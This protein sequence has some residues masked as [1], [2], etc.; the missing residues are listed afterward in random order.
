MH[1]FRTKF[2]QYIIFFIV[3]SNEQLYAQSVSFKKLQDGITLYLKNRENVLT[4]IKKL[5]VI[6]EDIIRVQ[7]IPGNSDVTT[8]SIMIVNGIT[9]LKNWQFI[10]GK[11]T[12]TIATKHLRAIVS[13]SSGKITFTDQNNKILTYERSNSFSPINLENGQSA[14]TIRQDFNSSESEAIYGLGQ[15]QQGVVNYKNKNVLLEQLNTEVSIPFW[16]SSK[17]YGILWDNNSLSEYGD[18]RSYKSLSTLTLY[19]KDGETV[20]LTATYRN[21]IDTSK[22][23]VTKKDTSIHY[24]YLNE[25]DKFPKEFPLQEGMVDWEGYLKA[26]ESGKY[27]FLIKYAGYI[28]IWIA[29]KL[30]FDRWRQAWNPGKEP[31]ELALIRNNKYPIKIQW[32]PDG[33]VSYLDVNFLSPIPNQFKNQYSFISQAGDKIDYYFIHGHTSDEIIRGYR[34]LTGKA[35][36]M[37]KWAMGFWQSRQ[38]YKTQSEIINTVQQFRERNI[39]LDNIVLDWQYWKPD[40][41]GS[42]EFDTS[43]FPEPKR[44]IDSLHNIYH[45]NIMISVWPKFNEG[46]SNYEY[47]NKKGW[48]FTKNIQ[49]RRKD[50]L[51]YIS[52]FYDVFNPDARSAFWQLID[53]S[54]YRKGIDAWW[55][56]ASEPDIHSML[57]IPERQELMMP[58]YYG[59]AIKY[60]NAFSVPNAQAIYEGQRSVDSNKRVFILTRSGF[61]G[62][63][64][65]GAAVWSGDIAARWSDMSNQIAAGIN[66]SYSGNPYWTMDIGGFSVENRYSTNPSFDAA[67]EWKE[68]LTR[69]YQFGAFCPLFRAHGEYPFREIYNIAQPN[70]PAYQSILYYDQLR[71]KLM[72][73]IYSLAGKVYWDDYTIMR[74]LSMDFPS[75]KNVLNIGDQYLFGPSLLI[76]PVT[77]YRTISR[78]V[79][80]PADTG[81][82]NIYNGKYY[83]GGQIITAAAP[84]QRIPVFVRAGSIIPLGCD[85]EYTNQKKADTISLYVY[86]GKDGSFNLYED[87]GINYNYEKGKYTIIP[88][89]Y[90]NSKRT[91]TIDNIIS[92]YEGML[93]ERIFKIVL[94]DKKNEVGIDNIQEEH[95]RYVAYKNKKVE[96]KINN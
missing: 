77:N 93:S 92:S 9:T 73:Y 64:R 42:Q 13:L 14:Y 76:N 21:K 94:I 8:A 70:E 75:D 65:Y 80:L 83:K 53:S 71:Y 22:I 59:S 33:D 49:L 35:Q 18:G 69:W 11:N 54:L 28:K 26:N 84:Y 37:P 60:F 17:N 47:F 62:L 89:K 7:A 50:W 43:R 63:Q 78:K 79:Y 15:H 6:N 55:L 86:A 36:I 45:T 23:Y 5:T 87:E 39:P 96:I 95:F 34:Y 27:T 12:I 38:R 24:P 20:G 67:T 32:I 85:M 81:W 91:I 52:T 10:N 1:F 72:P 4:S 82:Y 2:I 66:F 58:N 68:L 25:Q 51:G 16:V 74:G 46:I 57:S 56:D 29:G 31:I 3:L 40:E 19:D 88:I 90:D 41:W 44:M 61:A 30:L 48:L